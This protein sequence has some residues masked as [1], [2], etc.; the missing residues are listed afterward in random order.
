MLTYAD[1]CWR[2]LTYADL[3]LFALTWLLFLLEHSTC[4]PSSGCD[5]RNTDT[6]S[7]SLSLMHATQTHSLSHTIYIH[8][9][10]THTHTHTHTLTLSLFFFLSLSFS[11]SLFLSLSLSLSHTHTP[12]GFLAKKLKQEGEMV[13]VDEP[14]AVFCEEVCLSIRQHTSAY[15][16]IRQHTSVF[17]EE[18]YLLCLRV[19]M[20]ICF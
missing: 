1:V 17:C 2:M 10:C 3:H 13:A 18:V 6:H 7:L 20:C 15:V 8:T 9:I 5:A 12:Q 19:C 4:P 14:I 16:S 11:L